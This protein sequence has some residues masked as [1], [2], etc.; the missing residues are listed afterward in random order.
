MYPMHICLG[1][2]IEIMYNINMAN[3][4]EFSNDSSPELAEQQVVDTEIGKTTEAVRVLLSDGSIEDATD[5]KIIGDA[6]V[7]L[8]KPSE[9]IDEIKRHLEGIGMIL[10]MNYRETDPP[11]ALNE[12]NRRLF[13]IISQQRI[14]L[15][16][17]EFQQDQTS[18][19]KIQK[20]IT[21]ALN[22]AGVLA[23]CYNDSTLRS[24]V[25]ELQTQLNESAL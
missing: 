15:I 12:I 2:S 21:E 23:K 4:S 10:A 17:A 24:R 20:L 9:D 16:E 19:E 3:P 22:S 1:I 8:E 5:I 18:R 7:F 6:V 14:K 11:P 25:L 13:V